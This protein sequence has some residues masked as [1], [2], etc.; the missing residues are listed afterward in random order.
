MNILPYSER[1]PR[2]ADRRLGASA[3]TIGEAGCLLTCVCMA[4]QIAGVDIQPGE[5]NAL[6]RFCDGYEKGDLLRWYVAGRLLGLRL[7]VLSDCMWIPAPVAEMRAYLDAGI[8][9]ICQVD[10]WQGAPNPKALHWVLWINE[11]QYIDP[12]DGQT[13][14]MREPSRNILY[15][16]VYKAA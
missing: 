7:E 12:Y 2:W 13:K 16:A 9:V 4:A 8:P 5:L 3:Q 15:W 14:W 1:D 6:L 11:R 10:D